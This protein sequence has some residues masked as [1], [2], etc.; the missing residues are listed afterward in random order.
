MEV[1]NYTEIIQNISRHFNKKS[2]EK[3][4][5]NKALCKPLSQFQLSKK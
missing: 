2:K 4:L 5:L 3:K 1:I